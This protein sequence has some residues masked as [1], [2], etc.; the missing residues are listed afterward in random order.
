MTD[1]PAA[2]RSP[3]RPLLKWTGGK[4]SEIP[5]LKASYPTDIRRI[6]EPFSGGAAV[7]FDLNADRIVLND[8]S[9]GLVRFYRT[10][11]NPA[12]RAGLIAALTVLDVIRKRI[13]ATVAG[14]TDAQVEQVFTNPAIASSQLLLPHLDAWLTELPAA[15]QAIMRA[16]LIDQAISK[17]VRRIPALEIKRG[18]VF[19]VEQ[20][21]EHLETGL[22]AGLYT[23]MR[24]VYN[25]QVSGLSDAWSVAAWWFVRALCYSGMF[26]YGKG[27]NFNVPYGGRGYNSRD[28]TGSLRHLVSSAVVDFFSRA[29]IFDMDFQALFEHHHYFG[30]GDFIFVDPPYDSAFSKYNHEGSFGPE[31]QQR[32]ARTLKATQAPW[33]MV[34]KNTPFILSLYQDANLYRGVFDKQYQ[35]NFRNR[36]DRAAE[37]LVVANYPLTY[38]DAGQIGIQRLD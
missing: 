3:L 37:H 23:A 33:M 14:L 30:P 7:A 27:G 6:V 25:D 22:Q 36:H 4:R 11:Q 17:S 1:Q 24:R 35:V 9:S 18:E 12:H 8:L 34:I 15:L 5:F 32:L 20:R 13:A 10:L 19:T 2:A 28:F 26:R 31:D 16:D 21:R 29:T 38:V